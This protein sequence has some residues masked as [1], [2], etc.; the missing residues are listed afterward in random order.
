MAFSNAFLIVFGKKE[1]RRNKNK[2]TKTWN[3]LLH[4]KLEH[5]L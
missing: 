4:R 2:G 3:T 5:A 1:L